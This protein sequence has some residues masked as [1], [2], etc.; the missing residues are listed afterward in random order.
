[1]QTY[2]VMLRRKRDGAPASTLKSAGS[3]KEA[4]EALS[5]APWWPEYDAL[6]VTTDGYEPWTYDQAFAWYEANLPA[7]RTTPPLRFLPE[8]PASATPPGPRRLKPAIP[9][10]V[11]SNPPAD[12]DY[13][14]AVRSLCK[15]QL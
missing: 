10:E 11:W 6:A 5:Q 8:V 12:V 9:P 15:G 3:P 13:M 2:R 4:W 7:W 1:M 14:A